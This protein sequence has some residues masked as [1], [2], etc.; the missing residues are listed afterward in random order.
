M[1]FYDL[2]LMG[3]VKLSMRTVT[4]FTLALPAGDEKDLLDRIGV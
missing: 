2:S 3:Q 1:G 4:F